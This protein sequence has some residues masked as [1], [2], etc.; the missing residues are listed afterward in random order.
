[1]AHTY[2]KRFTLGVALTLLMVAFAADS[3]AAGTPAGTVISNTAT[4][5]YEDANANAL[6]AISNTVTTTVNQVSAVDIS[7][8]TGSL[9][10]DPGDLVCY[11]HTVSNNGND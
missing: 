2:I 11:A 8:P 6:Q 1:M 5:D 10:A 4:A 7:P 9:N 3:F